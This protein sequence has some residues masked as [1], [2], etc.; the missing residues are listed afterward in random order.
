MLEDLITMYQCIFEYAI[1][2]SFSFYFPAVPEALKGV[3]HPLTSRRRRRKEIQRPGG[4]IKSSFKVRF[5]WKGHQIF[6]VLQ[7]C[8]IV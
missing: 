1:F 6:D 4:V 7:I 3:V 2:F 5:G 8:V